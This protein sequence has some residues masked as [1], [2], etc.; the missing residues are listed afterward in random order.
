MNQPRQPEFNLVIG[1]PGA[2]KSTWVAG[3]AKQTPRNV[4]LVKLPVNIDDK[5]FS[6]LPEKTLSSWRQ[7]LQPG[8]PGK[9]KVSASKKEYLKEILPWII[10]GNFKNGIFIVDDATIYERH[11]IS[12]ELDELLG[13]RRHFGL[14]VY[15]V[16]HGLTKCPIDQFA[17]ANHIILFNCTD[18]PNYKASKIPEHHRLIAGIKVAQ[19][20]Y[21]KK[22]YKPSIIKLY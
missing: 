3:I 5:A 19:E 1:S 22:T 18:N 8:A 21:R 4:C 16:Y 13:M 15:L 17:F 20:E 12:D 14:D 9:F 7:G 11:Q 6:F 2:G 10:A